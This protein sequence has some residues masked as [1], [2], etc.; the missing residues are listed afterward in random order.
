VADQA[1]RLLALKQPLVPTI[2]MAAATVTASL[3]SVVR[4]VQLL[5][6][7]LAMTIVVTK[8]G[9]V[10]VVAVLLPGVIVVIVAAIAKEATTMAARVITMAH[11]LLV[12]PLGINPTTATDYRATVAIPATLAMA[13]RRR[14]WGHHLAFLQTLWV[15]HLASLAT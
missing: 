6:G 3:G 14:E 5:P 11:L 7:A 9:V 12:P 13:A 8:G 1:G 10:A 2:T 4:L 15:H